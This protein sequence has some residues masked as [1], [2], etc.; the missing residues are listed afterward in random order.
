M[1]ADKRASISLQFPL[2]WSPY[3]MFRIVPASCLLSLAVLTL[4]PRFANAQELVDA[5]AMMARANS[6]RATWENFPGF[7]ADVAAFQN[8]RQSSGKLRVSATGEVKLEMTEPATWAQR[9]LESLVSHRMPSDGPTPDVSFA[10]DQTGHPCGRLIR[11]IGDAEMGSMFRVQDDVIREVHRTAKESRF[12]ITVLDVERNA[13]GRVLPAFYTVSFWDNESGNLKSTTV[14]RDEWTRIG[15][16]DLP[17]RVHSI[18]VA[19]DGKRTVYQI[20]LTNHKSI[21][22]VA[23][24]D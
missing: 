13:E 14:V 4:V 9:K 1:T 5:S 16:W 7:E 21:E 10:D 6:A 19:D 12:V 17:T 2:T 15:S 18:E 23:A 3:M 11:L 24:K 20:S 22:A 8:E